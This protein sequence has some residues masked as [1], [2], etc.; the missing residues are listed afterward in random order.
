MADEKQSIQRLR[1]IYLLPNLLTTA[2]L[3]AGFYA[4]IAGMKGNF[5]TAAIAI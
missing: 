1:G 5:A 4:I 3:L 2:S